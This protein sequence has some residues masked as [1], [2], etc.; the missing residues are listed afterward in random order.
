[1]CV[2][3]GAEN[4]DRVTRGRPTDIEVRNVKIFSV[5][6]HGWDGRDFPRQKC[7]NDLVT[8]DNRDGCY[9]EVLNINIAAFR[10]HHA[11]QRILRR[12]DGVNYR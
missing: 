7:L 4:R 3:L 6:R 9:V 11:I 12:I 10:V 1:M 8:L 5:R 2:S